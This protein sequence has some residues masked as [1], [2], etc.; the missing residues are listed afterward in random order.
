MYIYI[1]RNVVIYVYFLVSVVIESH[2]PPMTGWIPVHPGALRGTYL[3]L[4]VTKFC[5]PSSCHFYFRKSRISGISV[6]L[7]V[8]HHTV[9][10]FGAVFEHTTTPAPLSE[11]ARLSWEEP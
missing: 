4:V 10:F 2:S 9:S 3:Y 8:F 11:R 6:L 5:A 1:Y 7:P